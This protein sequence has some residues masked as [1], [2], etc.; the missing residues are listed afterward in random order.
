MSNTIF[1]SPERLTPKKML[2]VMETMRKSAPAH[3]C[4][5]VGSATMF[6]L[7]LERNIVVEAPADLSAAHDLAIAR[8]LSGIDVKVSPALTRHQM[9]VIE[10]DVIVGVYDLR[11]AEERTNASHG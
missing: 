8:P 3:T 4:Y 10:N 9:A 7:W 2:A 1:H 11:P 6:N 5:N